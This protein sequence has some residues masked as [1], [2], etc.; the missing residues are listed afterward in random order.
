MVREAI[1][2]LVAF[3]AII[4][5]IFSWLYGVCFLLFYSGMFKQK[6]LM[7]SGLLNGYF[8]VKLDLAFIQSL[9]NIIFIVPSTF[10]FFFSL[11][12]VFPRTQRRNPPGILFFMYGIFQ[13]LTMNLIYVSML[14]Y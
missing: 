4:A 10:C 13:M 8:L 11:Y 9:Y 5:L 12:L 14:R 7:L 1:L 3:A 6:L 2:G